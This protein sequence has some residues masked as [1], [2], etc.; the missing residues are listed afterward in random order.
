M[1]LIRRNLSDTIEK[2]TKAAQKS[3]RDASEITLIAV[4]K[5][6]DSS[7]INE[8]I[9]EGVTVIGENRVQEARDKFGLIQSGVDWHLIGHLQTNKAKYVPEL[10]STVHSLE[11]VDLA[12]ALEKHYGAAGKIVKVMIEVNVSGE[13]SKFGISPD[14]AVEFLK[15]ISCFEHLKVC[16]I[17]TVAPAS[18]DPETVRPVFKDTRRLFERLKSLNISNV[19]LTHISMG[20]SSDYEVAVQEGATMVRVGSAIFGK[21][22]YV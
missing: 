13:E 20:M 5:T 2:I 9:R 16:G 19:E 6:V 3:G 15:E 4:T 22:I 17:M 21:R 18:D 7:R 1:D 11:S 12:K 10:F 14:Y 8:A